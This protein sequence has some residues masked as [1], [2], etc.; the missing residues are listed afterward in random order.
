MSAPWTECAM[1]LAQSFDSENIQSYSIDAQCVSSFAISHARD[2]AHA[3]PHLQSPMP[4]IMPTR[5]IM[6]GWLYMYA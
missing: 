3:H 5:I 1:E 4:A 6:R 2:C